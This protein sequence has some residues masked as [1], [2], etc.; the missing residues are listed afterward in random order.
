MTHNRNKINIQS[1]K[2][3][4][5]TQRNEALIGSH[6]KSDVYF[7]L[8][9]GDTVIPAHL[10][11][12]GLAS[13]TLAHLIYFSMNC[14]IQIYDTPVEDFMEFLRF[15][16]TDRAN[17]TIKNAVNV[18]RLAH[19]YE[20]NGLET[21][22]CDFLIRRLRVENICSI[23][24]ACYKIENQLTDECVAFIQSKA[25]ILLN[26]GIFFR[27]IK[28]TAMRK[29]V[30]IVCLNLSS[31]VILENAANTW[32]EE[33]C[34]YYKLDRTKENIK[35]LL[36]PR[37]WAIARA[38]RAFRNNSIL[39]A[40]APIVPHPSQMTIIA[41]TDCPCLMPLLNNH[42]L[43]EE[44]VVTFTVSEIQLPGNKTNVEFIRDDSKDE[45]PG[46]ADY[47]CVR[48]TTTIRFVRPMQLAAT[49]PLSIRFKD[50]LPWP[51]VK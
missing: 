5:L 26:T 16:Y 24:N 49:V 44:F 37:K 48:N 17:I 4:Y 36:Q 31:K 20:V 43:P 42:I 33:R 29:L 32:A 21:K 30:T 8:N 41:A 9:N 50:V 25:E 15:L 40:L 6:F 39:T 38:I 35:K 28:P 11:I 27:D 45:W 23:Y 13:P 14:R 47:H 51:A 18:M 19:R 22:C 7:V 12:V 46:V 3:D 10:L 1:L 34:D 2:K